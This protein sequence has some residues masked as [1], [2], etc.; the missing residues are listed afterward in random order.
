MRIGIVV[1]SSDPETVWNVFR[2]ANFSLDKGEDVSVFLLGKGVEAEKIT[3]EKFN[4]R[5]QMEKFAENGGRI[6]A[7]GTCLRIR[8]VEAEICPISTMNDL[9]EIVKD[10]DKLLTF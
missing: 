6:L 7:C 1:S 8:N 4:V 5:E 3:H 10:S 9:Y 2:F